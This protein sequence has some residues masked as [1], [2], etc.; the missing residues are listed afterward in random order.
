MVSA[1]NTKAATSKSRSGSSQHPASPAPPQPRRSASA[2]GGA[3]G[4]KTQGLDSTESISTRQRRVQPARSRRGGPGVGSC[5]SDM[6]ILETMKRRCTSSPSVIRSLPLPSLLLILFPP[7]FFTA[8]AFATV[9]RESVLT[10]V[11]AVENEP[12]IPATTPFL[13]TTNSALVPAP[14]PAP[15]PNSNSNSDSNAAAASSSTSEAAPHAQ[16]NPLAYSRYF[17]RPEVRR[18]YMEQQLIQTPEFSELPQDAHVGGRFRPRNSE[19]V[20]AFPLLFVPYAPTHASLFI[21]YTRRNDVNY[22]PASRATPL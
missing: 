16:L 1:R 12:L 17:D 20:R 9:V 2:A 22:M 6:M 10:S 3:A 4:V 8:Y 7:F 11:C 5:E 21:Y 18:A 14:A 15:G 19:D 13:L